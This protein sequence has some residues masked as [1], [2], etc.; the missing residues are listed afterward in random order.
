LTDRAALAHMRMQIIAT[1]VDLPTV[2]M[3]GSAAVV[4]LGVDNVELSGFE[5]EHP[6]IMHSIF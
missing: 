4:D 2:K 5:L 3:L 1:T 6:A